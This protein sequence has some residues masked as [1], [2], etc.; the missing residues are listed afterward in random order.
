MVC[1]SNLWGRDM[2]CITDRATKPPLLKLKHIN[3]GTLYC[4]NM[5]KKRRFYEE[6]LGITCIQ[7][8]DPSMIIRM[9]N[10]NAYAVVEVAKL[11]HN[12][13]M[14]NHNGCGVDTAQD[15]D[16]SYAKIME[17]KEEYGIQR[18]TKPTWLHGDYNFYLVD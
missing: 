5:A 12:M 8:S 11:P 10:G 17:V 6:V 13:H 14:L 15:V 9:G 18:V 3:L 16:A 1:R 4:T 7:L 2:P